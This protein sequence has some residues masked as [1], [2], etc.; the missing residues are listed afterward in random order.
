MNEDRETIIEQLREA[1]CRITKQRLVILDCILN[2]DPSCC[3][4]IY[5]EA[6]KIDPNIGSAT[7]YRMINTL[8]EIGVINRKNM[9]QVDCSNCAKRDAEDCEGACDKEI[10]PGCGACAGG[11]ETN[12]VVTLSDNSKIVLSRTELKEVLKAGLEA[13]GKLEG[14]SVIRVVL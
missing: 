5:A 12:V 13:Q 6:A 4:E 9:Y 7:V 3:K 11:C 1:G 8:E 14:K 2:G 10:Q